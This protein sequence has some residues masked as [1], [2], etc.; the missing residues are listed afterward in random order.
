MVAHDTVGK[1]ITYAQKPADVCSKAALLLVRLKGHMCVDCWR[2]NVR[3]PCRGHISETKQERHI[4]IMEHYIEV[5][6]ADSVAAFRL[7]TSPTRP[8]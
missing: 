5:G 6:A 8:L 3:C 1:C 2:L 4:I 7:V